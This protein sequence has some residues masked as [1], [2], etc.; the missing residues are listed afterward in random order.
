MLFFCLFITI[1]PLYKGF[2]YKVGRWWLWPVHTRLLQRSK[3]KDSSDK[4][5]T[6]KSEKDD[7]SEKSEKLKEK[8]RGSDEEDSA[9]NQPLIVTTPK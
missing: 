1:G 6:D 5:E 9:D 4:S 8:S 2:S 7:K 3:D